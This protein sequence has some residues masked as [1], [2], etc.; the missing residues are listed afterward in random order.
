MLSKTA[1]N[2]LGLDDSVNSVEIGFK[3]LMWK[4]GVTWINGEVYFDKNWCDFAETGK[5]YEGDIC[6]FQKKG[7]PTHLEVAVF[8][9]NQ[10]Q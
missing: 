3:N 4:V 5:L 10:V 2:R 7:V 1:Y 6:V 9:N 8:E